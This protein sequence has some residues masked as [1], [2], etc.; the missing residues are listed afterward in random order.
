[1]DLTLN[2]EQYEALIAFAR[3][4]AETAQQKRELDSY[5]VSLEKLNGVVRYKLWVQWQEAEAPLPATARFPANWPPK[6][7]HYIELI[8]RPIA[9]IDV[10]QVLEKY[11]QKP[12]NILV[13]TDPAATVGWT[14]IDGFFLP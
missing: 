10:D 7:R 1:M 3:R 6:L 12:V 2:Q 13:T 8:S 11:A 14:K 4:G 5:L 9:R